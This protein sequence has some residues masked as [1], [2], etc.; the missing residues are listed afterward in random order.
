MNRFDPRQIKEQAD[1]RLQAAAYSPRR[2]VLLHTGIALVC[3]LVLTLISY[4]LNHQVSGTGGL[5]GIGTRSVLQSMQSVLSLALTIILPFW[6]FGF[7]AAAMRYARQEEVAP[8]NLLTGLRRFAPLLRLQLLQGAV[9]L[10]LLIAAAQL[11]STVVMLTPLGAGMME[12]MESLMQNQDFIQTGLFP[13]EM[14]EQLIRAAIPVYAV[15]GLLFALAA[16]PVSYRLRLAPYMVLDGQSRA[17]AAMVTSNRKMKGNCVGFFKLDL[18]FWWYWLL[19]GVCSLLAFGDALLPALGLQ[20]PMD[21]EAA[22][23]LFYGL[24]LAGSLALAYLW[25]APVETT[26]ATAYDTLTGEPKTEE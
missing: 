20:L 21:P 3:S 13:E 6:E 10:L 16:I 17:L 23:F 15:S 18:L 11:A 8:R 24:Q 22:M 9:Y 26:Y 12:L 19:Q 1:Q 2:L 5:A 14:L 7:I 4:F 25:R